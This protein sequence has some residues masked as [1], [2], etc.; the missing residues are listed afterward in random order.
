MLY[1]N[2]ALLSTHINGQRRV[3]KMFETCNSNHQ[4][5]KRAFLLNLPFFSTFSLTDFNF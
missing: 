5:R 1:H 4:A 3:G 2:V